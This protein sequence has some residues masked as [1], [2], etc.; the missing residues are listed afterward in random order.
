MKTTHYKIVAGELYRAFTTKERDN[1]QR[2][3]LLK[4][5]RPEWIGDDFAADFHDAMGAVG[6]Q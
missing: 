3:Y 4:A 1:G 5:N 6:L 2:F